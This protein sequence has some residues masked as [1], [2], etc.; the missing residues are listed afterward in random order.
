[1]SQFCP[2]GTVPNSAAETPLYAVRVLTGG[3][4]RANFFSHRDQ[5]YDD[6]PEGAIC[7][8]LLDGQQNKIQLDFIR[9]KDPGEILQDSG[10]SCGVMRGVPYLVS[11]PSA[12]DLLY[13]VYADQGHLQFDPSLNIYCV[14]LEKDSQ[15]NWR[16]SP[17]VRVNTP[18]PPPT[19]QGRRSHEFQ[20]AATV[21]SAGR[22]HVIYYSGKNYADPD[23]HQYDMFYAISYDHGG[24][25]TNYD[26]G[27]G[28]NDPALD[29]DITIMP[30]REYPGIVV[31]GNE[32]WALY[33]GTIVVP[34][35]D[36]GEPV[37][38]ANRIMVQ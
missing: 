1:M 35:P 23:P 4:I 30:P 27:I 5:Y 18:D 10:I 24:S 12:A 13:V 20:P 36:A 15:G 8:Y 6:L 17:R 3:G 11:E 22:V 26:L 14:R 19:P 7:Y 31:F 21:D 25:F 32:L 34:P 38:W 16:I 37:I 33:P 29:F 28:T 2:Q 9:D